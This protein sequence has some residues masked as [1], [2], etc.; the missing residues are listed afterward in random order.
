[1][2]ITGKSFTIPSTAMFNIVIGS[3]LGPFMGVLMIYYSFRYIE[4]SRSSIVQSLKGIVVLAGAWLYFGTLPLP[5]Q[6]WGGILT[7]AGV[8][9]M[10]LAQARLLRFRPK[11]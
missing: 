8:L 9:I 10:T 2:G 7:V 11:N 1:M 4:A 3:F 6:V 5:H